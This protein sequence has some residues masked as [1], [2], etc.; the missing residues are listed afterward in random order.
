MHSGAAVATPNLIPRAS[1]DDLLRVREDRR[2]MGLVA[3]YHINAGYYVREMER[4]RR[5][6]SL[7]LDL[8]EK[9]G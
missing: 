6:T 5:Q 7:V 8:I 9:S 1:A 4:L 2:F 3:R